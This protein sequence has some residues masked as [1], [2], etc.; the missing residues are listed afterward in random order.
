[1]AGTPPGVS[2]TNINFGGNSGTITGGQAAWGYRF[3][4]TATSVGGSR[5]NYDL[6]GKNA[7]TGTP[8]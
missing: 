7:G 3:H 5:L 1:V 6:R 2:F 8:R 4:L